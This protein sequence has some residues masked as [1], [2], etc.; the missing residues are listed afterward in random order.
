MTK[1]ANHKEIA[2]RLKRDAPHWVL[3][4][5]ASDRSAV[6]GRAAAWRDPARQPKA[7]AGGGFE[8]RTYKA[9]EG[10]GGMWLEGRY[11]GK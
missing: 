4:D 2:E 1:R 5:T 7:F 9:W 11:I 6:A 10:R 3:I 8:F